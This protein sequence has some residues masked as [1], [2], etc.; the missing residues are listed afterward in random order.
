[1]FF[2]FFKRFQLFAVVNNKNSQ[3]KDIFMV[4]GKQIYHILLN[5][6]KLIFTVIPKNA[7]TSVKYILLK[8]INSDALKLIDLTNTDS[9]HNKTLKYFNFVSHEFCYHYDYD[10][11]KI[12][13]VRNPFD[14]LVSGWYNKIRTLPKNNQSRKRFGF[15]QYCTFDKF[16]IQI[17]QTKEE[18]LDRHFIPQYRFI[19]HNNRIFSDIILR[20]EDLSNEWNELVQDLKDS[21]GIK[22]S[23]MVVNLNNDTERNK[24]YRK[25]Y[26]K[27]LRKLVETKFETDLNRFNYEF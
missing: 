6:E 10:Y 17:Y 2:L 22:L 8:Y 25:Y 3:K 1:V 12:C 27:K 20:F 4:K 18:D 16:I 13:I 24:D 15:N 9:F 5:K 7:N 23:N 26:D 19:T 11:L 14:R 21:H